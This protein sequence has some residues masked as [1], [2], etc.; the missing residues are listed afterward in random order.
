ML[1]DVRIGWLADTPTGGPLVRARAVMTRD[2]LGVDGV[3]L[4]HRAPEAFGDLPGL[5]VEC[6]STGCCGD[7]TM[8]RHLAR[9]DVDVVVADWQSWHVA[10]GDRRPHML[11]GFSHR[12][13]EGLMWDLDE[14]PLHPWG[15]SALIGQ[16]SPLE[17]RQLVRSQLGLI[18]EELVVMTM[19]STTFPGSVE[20]RVRPLLAELRPSAVHLVAETAFDFFGADLIVTNAG[21]SAATEARWSG[22]PH[23][24]L[25]LGGLDQPARVCGDIRSALVNLERH[26][27]ADDDE[28][29]V[30]HVPDFVDALQ[31]AVETAK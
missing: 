30:D 15:D 9:T 5:G 2:D 16:H 20:S 6:V 11:I 1:A 14:M 10:E 27:P 3:V 12:K 28:L 18:E 4:S 8:R 31:L 13:T 24:L 19:S 7:D 23:V 29:I 22:V 17:R 25:M 21:W 26:R